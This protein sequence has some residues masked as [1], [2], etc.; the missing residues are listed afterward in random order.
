M[1]ETIKI[2]K[3]S[4]L[5]RM[6]AAHA[7]GKYA[8]ELV[9]ASERSETAGDEILFHLPGVFCFS[10]CY[11]GESVRLI[12]EANAFRVMK[13]SEKS[14]PLLCV[15]IE[16]AAV[17]CDIYSHRATLQKASAEGRVTFGGKIKYATLVMRVSAEGDKATLNKKQYQELYGE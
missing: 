12:K 2:Q 4:L 16:D 1:T 6:L 5:K 15:K 3:R 17:L 8:K 9:K 11:R 13:K 14:E 7:L 10:L